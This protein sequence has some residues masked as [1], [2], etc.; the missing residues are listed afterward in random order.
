MDAEGK[1]EPE[2]WK[3]LNYPA[4]IDAYFKKGIKVPLYI[5]TGD[6]DKFDIAYHAAVLYQK[7]R[8][9]QPNKVEYRVVDGDHEWMVWETT[10]GDAMKYMFRYTSRPVGQ[11]AK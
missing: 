11:A 1:F 10:I 6:H 5:N 8:E 4:F 3:K 7:L 2:T 9:Y